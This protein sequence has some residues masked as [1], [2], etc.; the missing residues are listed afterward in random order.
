MIIGAKK[1]RKHKEDMK[2]EWNHTEK[3]R[4]NENGLRTLTQAETNG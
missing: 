1:R 2:R 4:K 3:Q